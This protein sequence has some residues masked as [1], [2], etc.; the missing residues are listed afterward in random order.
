MYTF[1]KLPRWLWWRVRLSQWKLGRSITQQ[2]PTSKQ[3]WVLCGP[4]QESHQIS[5]AV[6]LPAGCTSRSS[7]CTPLAS[8]S[9]MPSSSTCQLSSSSPSSSPRCQRA[10]CCLQTCLSARPWSVWPVSNL[11]C[12]HIERIHWLVWGKKKRHLFIPICLLYVKH[13]TDII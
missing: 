2:V 8:S 7:W 5:R 6:P 10:G 1:N 3:W 4:A 9:L 12:L 11:Y 13:S